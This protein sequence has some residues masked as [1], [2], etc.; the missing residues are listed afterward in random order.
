MASAEKRRTSD[1][2]A[3]DESLVA[4]ENA[5]LRPKGPRPFAQAEKGRYWQKQVSWLPTPALIP[6]P[7]PIATGEGCLMRG[8]VP[9]VSA[10]PG[11][12]LV[13]Y[14]PLSAIATGEGSLAWGGALRSNTSPG[15]VL[16]IY[17]PCAGLGA[18]TTR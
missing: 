2:V 18:L 4:A 17:L 6:S 14:L 10:V 9:R 11:T 16:S 13:G 1:S 7:S 8:R 15:A 5:H 3:A 12:F